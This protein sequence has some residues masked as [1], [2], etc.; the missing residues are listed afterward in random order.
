MYF[1]AAQFSDSRIQELFNTARLI[2]EGDYARR[3]HI[4]LRGPYKDKGDISK[5]IFEKDAGKITIRK[6]G[7][8]FYGKQHTVHLSVEIMDLKE[9]WYKPDFPNGAPHLTLYD[10]EDRKFAWAVFSTLRRH[11]WGMT[12]NS[13]RLSVLEKKRTVEDDFLDS[14]RFPAK[15]IEKIAGRPVAAEEIRRLSDLDR[16]TMLDRTCNEIHRLTHP[17]STLQ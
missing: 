15:L 7:T 6:P 16:I 2:V 13:S 17:S 14:V 1:V 8:F 4:T 3:A 10:G 11:K 9:L 5:T 12:L